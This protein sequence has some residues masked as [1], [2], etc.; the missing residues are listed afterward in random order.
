MTTPDYQLTIHP[1]GGNTATRR[2]TAQP[3]ALAQEIH[4]HVRGLLGGNGLTIRL[5]GLTGAAWRGTAHVADFTLEPATEPATSPATKPGIRWGY[6]LADIDRM[7]RAACT[8]DRTLSSDAT[9][10]YDTAWSA[11]ALA[12]CEATQ[13]PTR[14]DLVRTG[15]QAIYADV[16][17]SRQMYGIDTTDRSGE[18][19]SAPRMVAYWTRIPHDGACEDRIDRIALDQILATLWDIEYDAIHALAAHGTYQA[20]ADTLGITY[21]A[22]VRNVNAA[23]ARFRRRWYAPDTAPKIRHTDR[24]VAA[25]GREAATHCSAGH[26]WTPENTRW[27]RG[28]TAA[29]AK[30]RR[31]RDCE[32]DRA[33]ARRAQAV[34][35]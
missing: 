7:A 33:Q 18:V 9:T 19:A 3:D 24:R 29:S 28:R 32:R 12:I 6:T 35:A 20:A 11:I 10:R 21:K 13:P 5:N 16:R 8:A 31:C 15:W 22:L 25:Y 27:D 30:V 14:A 4:R 17:A 23:R 2:I 34:A 26:E 1:V